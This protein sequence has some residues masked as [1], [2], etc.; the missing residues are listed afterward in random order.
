MPNEQI[1]YFGDTAH[2][3]YGEKSSQAI[4][5]YAQAISEFLIKFQCKIIVIA[6]NS[7][8]SVAYKNLSYTFSKKVEF[9][10]VVDPVVQG[11]YRDEELRHLGIIG[12]EATIASEIYKEKLHKLNKHWLLDSLATP[13][14][15]PMIEAGFFNNNISHAI[16]ESYLSR[17]SLESIDGIILACTHYPLIK[18]EII[19]FYHHKIK[20]FDSTDFV[21]KEVESRLKSLNLL[22]AKRKKE[23]HF[24]VSDYTESFEKTTKIFYK[25][26]IHL[27]HFALWDEK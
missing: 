18:P 8:S 10:N 15:A 6:C 4:N 13:L 7:A 25:E 16:I 9:V 2:L 23:H 14:L 24:F 19:D 1:I 12:T 11:I 22:S 27:E 3:P 26:K 17:K 20:V 5:I 21:A